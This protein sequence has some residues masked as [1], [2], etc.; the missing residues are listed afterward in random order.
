MYNTILN[1]IICVFLF[2]GSVVSAINAGATVQQN[3]TIWISDIPELE[4]KQ[5]YGNVIYDSSHKPTGQTYGGS[6]S[7]T[8]NDG[9]VHNYLMENYNKLSEN[10]GLTI[11]RDP[12]KGLYFLKPKSLTITSITVY[13]VKAKKKTSQAGNTYFDYSPGNILTVDLPARDSDHSNSTENHQELLDTATV[14]G[15]QNDVNHPGE[16]GSTMPTYVYVLFVSLGFILLG[17]ALLGYLF[18]LMSNR[19]LKIE[20]DIIESKEK[21]GRG[22]DASFLTMLLKKDDLEE[23]KQ[24]LLSAKQEVIKMI[25]KQPDSKGGTNFIQSSHES[26]KHIVRG[27]SPQTKNVANEF[28]GYAEMTLENYLTRTSSNEMAVFEINQKNGKIVFNLVSNPTIRQQLTSRGDILRKMR[29]NGI[30]DFDDEDLNGARNTD[31]GESG[32]LK[33]GQTP[34]TYVPLSPLKLKFVK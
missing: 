10:E 14:K 21:I 32:I 8:G 24:M 22:I 20:K 3:D 6:E 34:D 17:I 31:S 5:I 7:E 16:V 18:Y 19:F 11:G 26:I 25:P 15:D 33:A 2:C 28:L 1:N 27:E 12:Q 13:E 29:D 30:I 23:L 4:G 9:V